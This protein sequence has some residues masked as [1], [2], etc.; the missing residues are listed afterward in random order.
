MAYPAI[1]HP[2]IIDALFC[3]PKSGA[4]SKISDCVPFSQDLA[5]LM[6][7]C[8]IAGAI[9]AMSNCAQCQHRWNCADR[10][11]QEI[12]NAVA[13]NPKQLRGL[14]SYDSLR[15]GESLRWIDEAIT[16]GGLVG[17]YA[18]AECCISGLDTPR[19]YPLYGLCAKLRSPMVIDI[20]S[21]ERWTHHRPQVEVVAADFPELDILLA[22]PPRADSASILQL[23]QHFPRISFLLCPL[24][25]RADAVLCEYVELVGRER[26][27]F[28]S[29]AGGWRE[30]VEVALT[31]PLGTAAQRAYLAENATRLFK[32][33]VQAAALKM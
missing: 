6:N 29:S 12:V 27:L 15:I 21:H 32:F 31:L 11:T 30:A 5:P 24:E 2:A 23:M 13:A 25:L 1:A 16:E 19:M 10:R 7:S 22:T 18:E 20:T 9:L 28:R 17:A 3:I 26:V 14:A 4:V 8:G 33:P